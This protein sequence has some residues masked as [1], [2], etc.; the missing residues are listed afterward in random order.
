MVNVRGGTYEIKD[1]IVFD[2][3]D[4]GSS[5]CPII[6]QAY[7]GE[8][9]T[10]KGSRSLDATKIQKVTDEAVLDRLIDKTAKDNLYMID[11][12]VQGISIPE[13][14]IYS[15]RY[16]HRPVTRFYLNGEPLYE[17]RWPNA[18]NSASEYFTIANTG[19]AEDGYNGANQPVKLTFT[20][21]EGRA[22]KWGLKSGESF[23]IGGVSYLWSQEALRIDAERFDG[24]N[25]IVYT[26]DNNYY[27]QNTS[28][29]S[30]DMRR[31]IYFSNIF[32]EIDTEGESYIDRDKK[33]LYF[34][35]EGELNAPTLEIANRATP[36]S[37]TQPY[38]LQNILRFE[39]ASNI[40]FSGIDFKYSS[41][42]MIKIDSKSESITIKDA[43]LSGGGRKTVMEIDGSNHKIQNC[44]FS[45][46][47][48]TA[49]QL[50][51][52]DR[53]SL[54][55]SGTVLTNNKIHGNIIAANG[56][57]VTGVGHTLSH[58]EIYDIGKAGIYFKN[59]NN[60]IFE[61]NKVHNCQRIGDDGGALYWGRNI[62]ELG[63]IVR[64]NYFADMAES[65]YPDGKK[66]GA[67]PNNAI[68]IDDGGAGP[69]IYGNI[70]NNA[71]WSNSG[72]VR[73]NGGNNVNVHD[74]IIVNSDT[75]GSMRGW[76]NSSLDLDIAKQPAVSWLSHNCF[77]DALG[78]ANNSEYPF[79]LRDKDTNEITGDGITKTLML[80]QRWKDYYTSD[81]TMSN[82][83]NLFDYYT[84][85]KHDACRALY[86]KAIEL[87]KSDNA[88]DKYWNY[89]RAVD[90]LKTWV[91]ENLP[92][93]V[94]NNWK[95]NVYINVT[96]T[97]VNGTSANGAED[98]N[99]LN[100]GSNTSVF[101]DYNGSNYNLT[102]D[103]LA[104][105]RKTIPDFQA[106]DYSSMGNR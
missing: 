42:S 81:E 59:T 21:D 94:T 38:N 82:W 19:S 104:E 25:K 39:G 28:A 60:C 57:E 89:P 17:A 20:D 68:F 14:N 95:N 97:N 43:V 54:T 70:F 90:A 32:E 55:S 87:S 26:S 84:K 6:Y 5:D 67:N 80:S 3:N 98:S 30:S 9:V 40:T 83:A 29:S 52:G 34:Y 18:S 51:G 36:Y 10:L 24:A 58:N 46:F 15:S 62:S 41:D 2:S 103:A 79:L 86:D 8:A 100:L 72:P 74:N 4:S 31:Y 73:T 92:R 1:P 61:Y 7:N 66:F 96:N 76:D 22:A 106:P 88:L 77:S 49:I 71:G 27:S 85:E 48:A 11:L 69:E 93:I 35:H 33:I 63:N 13:V 37:D 64:Y 78:G 23:I 53:A 102:D 75:V 50:N 65:T 44:E 47:V 16:G 12:G 45:D 101:V 56:L 105:I 91:E 99:N